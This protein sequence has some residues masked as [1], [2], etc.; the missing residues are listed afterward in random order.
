MTTDKQI[1]FVVDDDPLVLDSMLTLLDS[2]GLAA[3]GY[4]SAQSFLNDLDVDMGGCLILDML[5][6]DITGLDLHDELNQ[7]RFNLPIIYVSGRSDIPQ[8]VQ[9][10]HMGAQDFLLKPIKPKL[11]LQRV[12]VALQQNA[13]EQQNRIELDRIRSRLQTL[14]SRESEVLELI[15]TG[16]TNKAIADRLHVGLRTIE[17]HRA[18][19]MVKMH[20]D[21]LAQLVTMV[22]EAR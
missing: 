14:S 2:V 7:K 8:A 15:V 10:M 1:V 16:Q 5:L 12:H 18:N 20:A 13:A 11:L 19:I 21:S 22:I 17:A 6:P 3:R 9:A 4:H